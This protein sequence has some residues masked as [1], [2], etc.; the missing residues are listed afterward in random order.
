LVSDGEKWNIVPA[1]DK[2]VIERIVADS[3]VPW[4]Y[5][6][7]AGDTKKTVNMVDI[8]GNAGSA[9]K[10]NHSIDIAG[11]KFDGHE[12]IV[13]SSIKGEWLDDG[14]VKASKLN[15]DVS[16]VYIPWSYGGGS[17]TAVKIN[18]DGNAKTADKVN[19][20]LTINK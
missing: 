8:S 7:N 15:A 6:S 16:D 3:Y 9:D 4:N 17:T 13:V 14:S 18:I 19:N 12:D 1:V 20:I 11:A 10:V 5:G 2:T